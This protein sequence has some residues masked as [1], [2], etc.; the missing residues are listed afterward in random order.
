MNLT[1]VISTDVDDKKRRK[2]K[3][4]RFGND[5]VQNQ[6]AVSPSGIDAAPVEDMVA[7]YSPTSSQE[8][9]VIIGYITREQKAKA[10]EIRIFSTDADGVEQ[11]AF[12]FLN[13]GTVE[14]GGDADN[15][16]RYRELKSAYDQLRDDLNNLIAQYN[17]H[18]HITTATVGPTA[19]PGV[20]SP[21][22]STGTPSTADMS[23]S[24]I[25]ELKTS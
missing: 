19:V 25:D 3:V 21:T 2:V 20:I 6:L 5:D 22:T 18:I 17:A 12:H 4:R 8:D 13:D 9:P 23:A 7:L 16:V 10:G 11:I 14:M 15:L 24:K 1:T